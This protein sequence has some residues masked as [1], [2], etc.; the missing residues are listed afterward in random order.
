MFRRWPLAGDPAIWLNSAMAETRQTPAEGADTRPPLVWD[1]PLRL[2]HWLL[3]I[4]I[5]GCWLT[6]EL[7]VE[8][9]DWHMRLG[10]LALGLVIFRVFWGFAGPRYARFS[11]FVRGPGEVLDYAGRWLRGEA[12]A[13]AGHN[14]LGGWSVLALLAIVSVQAVSGL[15]NSDD[16]LTSGPWRAAVPADFADA[17]SWLHGFNFNVLLALVAMHIA[18]VLFY[19]LKLRAGLIGAMLT[20]RKKIADAAAGIGGHRLAAAAALA[21]LAGGLVWLLIAMAPAPTTA[22]FTF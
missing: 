15:F 13:T 11:D 9:M 14:P 17:M 19:T 5:A 10:Y 8:Y 20:G 18:A 12:G 3:V 7:G 22:D 4:A 16:I 2:F 1:L 21:A 6:H